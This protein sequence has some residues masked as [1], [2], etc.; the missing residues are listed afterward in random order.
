MINR[1]PFMEN[2]IGEEQRKMTIQEHQPTRLTW[3]S[4][5][6]IM[7][8]V[9]ILAA[10]L[11]F[12]A[13]KNIHREKDFM[14]KS[15]LSQANVLIRSIE[16]GSRTGMA[17]MGWGKRQIQVLMEE[18]AQ[19]PD[20]LY[21]AILDENGEIVAHSEPDQVGKKA[22]VDLPTPNATTH[23]FHEGT[24]RS[25]DVIRL[26]EPWTRHRRGGRHAREKSEDCAFLSSYERSAPFYIMVGLDPL[27]L[28]EAMRQDMHQTILLFGMMFL[29][30]AAGFVSLVW[31]QHYRTARRSLRD[32]EI[33]TSTI[34]NEMPVGL[35]VTDPQ[36]RVQKLNPAAEAV[37]G[38]SWQSV[39]RIEEIP[40]P[41][42]ILH[43]LRNEET[44]VEEELL[45][46][47][48]EAPAIP[49]LVNA[50]IIRNSDR[51]PAGYAFLFSDLT[52]MKQLE[53]QIRRN[54]RL[55]SLGRLA[56]GIAHEIRNPLS[57]IKG[58][59]TILAGRS[60]DDPRKA[61]I[62]QVMVQEVER[63]NRVVSE[64]LDFARPTE[65]D[66]SIQPLTAI[67]RRS[68][69]LI[70]SDAMQ[71]NVSV[72][73]SVDPEDLQVNVDAD[74][75]AQVLLNLFLNALQAMEAGGILGVTA[76]TGDG[77]V[78]VRVSDTG[79]GIQA[80]SIPHIFDPYFTT[81]PGGVG[82]GLAN[83]HKLV[84]AH[85]GDIHVE[86]T[87]GNG[88]TF[89]IRLPSPETLPHNDGSPL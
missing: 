47:P 56:A 14:E 73:Y 54:E 71:S 2:R 48:K 66:R 79:T 10:I 43:R 83:A 42:S 30:G 86:S 7:G 21:V 45:C 89:V 39:S 38:S 9:C 52:E 25:Y 74:R 44:I 60:G 72:Q 76:F 20:V 34:L 62:Y 65:L 31:A 53:E 24:D 4:P 18:T 55:A 11:G 50:T 22:S 77:E 51:K 28:E 19:Q 29:V 41:A 61:Q 49:L 75:F 36:G 58:F 78:V 32:I 35:I 23:G 3:F 69:E 46:H 27:P 33:L 13:W 40:L 85:G 64:L 6:M 12:L 37:F 15:L 57:S 80:D 16:A 88:T 84:E 5:W 82:L 67:L 1:L 70:E 63:L 87:P 68:V 8:S 59:A 17:G 81:K 26:F